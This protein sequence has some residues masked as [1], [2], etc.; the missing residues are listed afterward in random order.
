MSLE[1]EQTLPSPSLPKSTVQQLGH[2]DA[3]GASEEMQDVTR[4]VPVLHAAGA[5]T[6][7]RALLWNSGSHIPS[8]TTMNSWVL[9]AFF[10]QLLQN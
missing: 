7:Q 4:K 9:F 8:L 5:W 6:W 1:I 10:L 2:C 3:K